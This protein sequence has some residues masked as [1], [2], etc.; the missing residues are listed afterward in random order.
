MKSATS[1]QSQLGPALRAD[2]PGSSETLG[3]RRECLRASE[4]V[5]G[6]HQHFA[7]VF[8]KIE[9]SA[10]EELARG[11]RGQS[12]HIAKWGAEYLEER[13]QR[14]WNVLRE[15][16]ADQEIFTLWH[17]LEL[18]EHAITLLNDAF[19]DP[20]KGDRPDAKTLEIYLSF[21]GERMSHIEKWAKE[22]TGNSRSS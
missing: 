16:D 13:V 14:A 4:N 2:P 22:H 17:E 11:I 5:E 6:F 9:T 18:L 12:G 10:Y 1:R 7:A 19:T 15:Y 20:H 3:K 8:G 21:V